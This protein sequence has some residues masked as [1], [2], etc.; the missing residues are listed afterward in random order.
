M[1]QQ[2]SLLGQLLVVS[3]D[4]LLVVQRAQITDAVVRLCEL[5]VDPL[6]VVLVR[7]FLLEIMRGRF[8]LEPLV[9]VIAFAAETIVARLYYQLS[10]AHFGSAVV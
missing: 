4:T 1:V 5:R 7:I 6:A 8:L 2:L 3:S 10:A 9:F